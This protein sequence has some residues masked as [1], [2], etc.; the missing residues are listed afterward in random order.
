MSLCV[1]GIVVPDGLKGYTAF[2]FR[3]KQSEEKCGHVWRYIPRCACTAVLHLGLPD[4]EDEG[5]TTLRT[6]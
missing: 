2:I 5:T 6:S 4:P 1:T 3:V